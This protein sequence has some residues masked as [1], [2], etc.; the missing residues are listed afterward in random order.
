MAPG[1]LEGFAGEVLLAVVDR[2]VGSQ[3]AAR[4]QLAFA[5]G[6]D[7]HGEASAF[8][9][10][11]GGRAY[12][13]GTRVQE[14][15]LPRLHPQ[16]VEQGRERR[17]KYL[18]HPRR[19]G[20]LQRPGLGHEHGRGQDYQ[21]RVTAATQ[22]R[23]TL[24]THLHVRHVRRHR[25]DRTGHL[26]TQ[27]LGLSVGYGVVA[28]ALEEI[29]PVERRCCRAQQHLTGPQLR[30]WHLLPLQLT[31][32]AY[33]DCLHRSPASASPRSP[34][35][36]PSSS[37]NPL[38]SSFSTFSLRCCSFS[39]WR[40]R[41]CTSCA[42]MRTSGPPPTA[43]PASS[44]SPSSCAPDTPSTSPACSSVSWRLL[45]SFCA[46]FRFIPSI[47]AAIVSA[48]PDSSTRLLHFTPVKLT[49]AISP[50]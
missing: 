17:Q 50:G 3:F 37:S 13:A 2:Q 24:V 49:P 35:A 5:A 19:P 6:S 16:V 14:Q 26:Q 8:R 39:R 34:S 20:Q 7:D 29:G 12:A 18:R 40:R 33:N 1:E 11:D 22:Q 48:A 38:A 32:G 42:S 47:Y 45:L 28:L 30:V 43:R 15:G 10:L 31:V 36:W 23:V 9:H 41:A 4:L 46:F 44:S 21:L 27:D 25:Y